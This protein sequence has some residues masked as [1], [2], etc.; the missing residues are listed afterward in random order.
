MDTDNHGNQYEEMVNGP[1][2]NFTE[3][4]LREAVMWGS[5]PMG[6]PSSSH[7]LSSVCLSRWGHLSNHLDNGNI[8]KTIF[9][10]LLKQWEIFH[11]DSSLKSKFFLK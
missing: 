4:E 11:L 6:P 5:T 9:I 3:E 7:I 2:E 8:I 1:A 10:L